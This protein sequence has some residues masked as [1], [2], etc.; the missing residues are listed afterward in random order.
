MIIGL[1]HKLHH[2]IE[3]VHVKECN[4]WPKVENGIFCLSGEDCF[5]SYCVQ[6]LSRDTF[7]CIILS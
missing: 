1:R 2:K 4:D 6:D 7:Q 5:I 3:Y